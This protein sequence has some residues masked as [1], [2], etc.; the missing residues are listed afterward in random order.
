MVAE[1]GRT[2]AVGR[3]FTR[4]GSAADRDA[5]PPAKLVHGAVAVEPTTLQSSL[6]QVA[7]VAAAA[8]S[9]LGLADRA[10]PIIVEG[11]TGAPELNRRLAEELDA[12]I[13]LVSGWGDDP[14][15][16]ARS[17]GRQLI[18]VVSGGLPRYRQH[19][20]ETKFRPALEAA[21]IA[22]FGAVPDDRR[23]LAV[24]VGDVAAHLGG[25]FVLG[26]EKS[27]DLIDYF[28]VGGNVWDWGVHYFSVRENAAAVIRGDRPDMQMAALATPIK[29]LV[30]TAGQPPVPIQYVQYEAEQEGVPLIVVP[31]DTHRTSALLETIQDRARFDHPGKMA[32]MRE[33]ADSA[34]NFGAIE[35]ALAQPVTR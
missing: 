17:L 22:Y 23:L 34:I 11:L 1:H 29:A 15:P 8:R 31:H 20:L 33:L 4:S 30:L 25:E 35:A 27:A 13:L 28:L 10:N 7:E 21:G 12:Q 26:R 6:P 24:T 16:V 18:G 14:V 2:P 5:L 3:A 19:T 9:I 32:R